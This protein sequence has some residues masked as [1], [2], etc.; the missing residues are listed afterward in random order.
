M[1]SKN[2]GEY[3]MAAL[4]QEAIECLPHGFS[5]MDGDLRPILAN[6]M[7]RKAFGTYFSILE[8]GRPFADAHFGSVRQSMPHLSDAECR[9]IAD[10]IGQHVASGT[11]LHLKADDGRV[12]NAIYRVMSGN[13]YVAVYVD[14]TQI[15]QRERE[16]KALKREAEAANQAKSAFLANM[17]HEIRTPLNGVLGMAQVL[18]LG[19]LSREYREQVEVILESGKTLRALMDDVLDL[20]KIEAGRMELAPADKNLLH[21]LKRQHDLWLPRAA[22]KGIDLRLHVAED[23]PADLHFD[24]I[25]FGQCL[26]NL[27]SNA[28]KFTERGHVVIDVSACHLPDGI[29]ISA[30]V[31]DT[32]IGMSAETAARLFAPFTQADSSISRRFGGTGLGLVITRKLAQL[33]GGDVVLQS[34]EAEGSSFTLTLLAQP[35]REPVKQVAEADTSLAEAAASPVT[36]G[37][38]ILLV[39]DH[40]LNRRVGRLFLEPQGYHITEAENGQQAL[41]K[42]ANAEFDL[43]LL[44]IHMPVLDGIETLKRLRASG[45]AVGQI[46]GHRPHRRRHERRPRA[47]SRGGHEWLSVEAH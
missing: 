20:S 2:R 23:V 47:L 11:A 38:R 41:D 5:I 21:V 28:I 43:I 40:P 10:R 6:R 27:I 1:S 4:V 44:D 19:D 22:E 9:Q 24:A 25:R 37:M 7:A 17:S 12:F 46:A 30:A 36:G 3:D 45:A 34:V 33:M 26:S 39:D 14:I 18:A 35:A 32:G 29:E 15:K 31:T 8:Q 16:L 42:L 13:R